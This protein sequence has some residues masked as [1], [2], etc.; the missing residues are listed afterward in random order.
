MSLY[1]YSYNTILELQNRILSLYNLI[2]KS[3][4]IKVRVLSFRN[5]EVSLSSETE[6]VFN[7]IM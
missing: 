2:G 6:R 3:K 7:K 1:L 4:N 5:N